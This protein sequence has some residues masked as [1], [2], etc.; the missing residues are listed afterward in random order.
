MIENAL[1]TPAAHSI[2]GENCTTSSFNTIMDIISYQKDIPVEL[3]HLIKLYYLDQTL[4][5]NS[6]IRSAVNDWC[7]NRDKAELRYGHIS[8]WNTS[9]VTN[10]I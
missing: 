6:N 5:N 2:D 3:R 8:Y 4:L 1:L 10:I 9:H 7:D